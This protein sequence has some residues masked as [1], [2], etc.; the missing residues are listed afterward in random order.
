MKTQKG[1]VQISKMLKNKNKNKNECKMNESAK[2]LYHNHALSKTY[3][4]FS[5]PKKEGVDWRD[6]AVL[7]RSAISLSC[8]PRGHPKEVE[9]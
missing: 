7:Q 5:P 3:P 8:A 1:E 9:D 6:R 2:R 4:S